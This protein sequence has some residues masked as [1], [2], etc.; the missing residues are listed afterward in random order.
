MWSWLHAASTR[1]ISWCTASRDLGFW[2]RF[3]QK[4]SRDTLLRLFIGQES[5]VQAMPF[6][7]LPQP[8]SGG[9]TGMDWKLVTTF[10][11]GLARL[12]IELFG[13]R[14]CGTSAD[15]NLEK[16]L[17][18]NFKHDGTNFSVHSGENVI[19]C[20]I[21]SCSIPGDN[22]VAWYNVYNIISLQYISTTLEILDRGPPTYCS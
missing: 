2:N 21:I 13:W 8:N 4:R 6:S 11:A 10:Q 15:F 5:M 12:N 1:T 3:G 9:S 18:K 16:I 19:I 17:K 14:S 20:E 22:Q 7:V